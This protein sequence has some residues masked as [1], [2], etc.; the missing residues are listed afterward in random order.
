MSD[1]LIEALREALLR[2]VDALEREKPN[3]YP[4]RTSDVRKENKEL[5]RKLAE[6]TQ[7][8]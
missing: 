6:L 1:E 7:P 4:A 2:M 3:K 5:R 8:N